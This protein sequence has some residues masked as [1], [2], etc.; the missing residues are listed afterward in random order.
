MVGRLYIGRAPRMSAVPSTLESLFA[1]ERAH[2]R[3][4]EREDAAWEQRRLADRDAAVAARMRADAAVA[5]R[6]HGATGQ[7]PQLHHFMPGSQPVDTPAESPSS[8]H[9]LVLPRC[10]HLRTLPVPR[11]RPWASPSLIA[12]TTAASWCFKA[13]LLRRLPARSRT[14]RKPSEI[15]PVGFAS[16]VMSALRTCS[17][18]PHSG[19]DSSWR[20]TTHR[21][22]SRRCLHLLYHASSPCPHRRLRP[23]SL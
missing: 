4:E 11:V 22:R 14:G 21:F 16:P 8:T 19:T 17:R 20:S 2:R 5:A 15:W 3:R 13:P 1:W 10:R 9:P 6:A 23:C 12:S 7:P 18:A